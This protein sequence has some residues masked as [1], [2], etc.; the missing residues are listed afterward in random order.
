MTVQVSTNL[1]LI[2]HLMRRAAFGAP[3]SA[4]E[5]Y[6]SL[7]YEAAID[8]LINVERFP[9]LDEEDLLERY[10]IQHADGIRCPGW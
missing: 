5:K 2:G 9:R 10:Y 6:S 8:D 7:G 1:G 4:L 3:A